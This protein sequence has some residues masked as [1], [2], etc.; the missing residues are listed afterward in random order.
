MAGRNSSLLSLLGTWVR[1]H[2]NGRVFPGA[3]TDDFIVGSASTEYTAA[4]T[5]MMFDQSKGAFRAGYIDWTY[6]NDASRGNYSFG[7]GYGGTASGTQSATFGNSCTASG[8]NTFAAG[9]QAVASGTAATALGSLATASGTAGLATGQDSLASRYGQRAH[10]S[11]FLAANGDAQ[12]NTFLASKITTTA[13]PAVLYFDGGSSATLTGTTTNVLTLPVS[14]AH[15][16]TVNAV[17]RRTDSTSDAGGWTITGTIVRGASGN[18]AFISTPSVVS[19]LSAGA[20][21]GTWALAAT[22]NTGDATNNYLVLTATGQT[23][24]T[25]RWVADITTAEVG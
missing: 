22:I 10:A 19:D 12:S 14:K 13:T 21:T 18:A 20:I 11:K 8:A 15:R 6:W 17:A 23:G 1:D 2:V 25:I 4:E 16:F 24:A 7:A 5:K 9:N 3:L